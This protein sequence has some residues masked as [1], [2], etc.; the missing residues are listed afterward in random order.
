MS[1]LDR[2][3]DTDID[4]TVQGSI[5]S[6]LGSAIF[7]SFWV[8]LTFLLSEDPYNYNTLIIGLFGLVGMTG[9]CTAPFVGRSIDRIVPWCGVV[10]GN[11]LLTVSNLLLLGGAQTSIG[12]VIVA[13]LIMDV[14]Q[15][16]QQV[17]SYSVQMSCG[18]K[19]M[20]MARRLPIR[21]AYSLRILKRGRGSIQCTSS[22]TCTLTLHC[23]CVI[24]HS[25]CSSA[26]SSSANS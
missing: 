12:F 6:G 13:I 1:H 14:G 4:E 20:C 2:V 18:C 22:G 3:T 15:Q 16:F 24:L 9:V 23:Q 25:Y 26:G 21:V 8:T 11:L 7:T 19:L 17:Q 10:L 5:T